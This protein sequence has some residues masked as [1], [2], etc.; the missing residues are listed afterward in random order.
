MAVSSV[1]DRQFRTPSSVTRLSGSSPD[2]WFCVP[3]S[4]Q[5]CHY[6]DGVSPHSFFGN[7]AVSF[8]PDP[9]FCV[10]S[11]TLA[12]MGTWRVP[13]LAAVPSLGADL[14]DWPW[15]LSRGRKLRH[16]LGEMTWEHPPEVRQP[17]VT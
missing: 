7:P 17:P 14:C 6:E 15:N 10:P 1:E 5:V 2:P 8:S 4:R 13:S 16:S 11:L 9:W 3:A 12:F